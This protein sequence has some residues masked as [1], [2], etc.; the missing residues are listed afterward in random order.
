MGARKAAFLDMKAIRQANHFPLRAVANP[1]DFAIL[2]AMG[3]GELYVFVGHVAR[4]QQSRENLYQKVS[5]T[6]GG[7]SLLSCES[8]RNWKHRRSLVQG[9]D[10][11]AKW[12]VRRR[13]DRILR[14]SP[15]RKQFTQ[16]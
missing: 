2:P 11:G 4:F 8:T 10:V 6:S 12:K 5:K 13:R 14:A 3:T 15:Q 9:R 7:R 16:K 1:N